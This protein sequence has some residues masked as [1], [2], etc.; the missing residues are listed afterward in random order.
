MAASRRDHKVEVGRRRK[1]HTSPLALLAT[2]EL[3]SPIG[4][5]LPISAGI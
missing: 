4:A 2:G 3:Q 1:E 5:E